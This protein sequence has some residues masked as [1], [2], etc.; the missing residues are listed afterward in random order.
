[1]NSFKTKFI[2]FVDIL[3]FKKFVADAEKGA[4]F[5]LEHILSL[6][7]YLGTGKE[8]ERFEKTGPICCPGAPYV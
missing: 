8:R 7:S 1:M 5:D 3:G 6:I 2:A 4:G